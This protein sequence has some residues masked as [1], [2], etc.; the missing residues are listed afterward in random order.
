VEEGW[1]LFP[2]YKEVVNNF[3]KARPAWGNPLKRIMGKLKSC[4]W[5]IK[6][7][8]VKKTQATDEVIATKTRELEVLQKGDGLMDLKR[9]RE[10]KDEIHGLLEQQDLKWKQRAK[11]EWL[12]KGD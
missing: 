8:V 1:K 11:E 12:L 9:E 5:P 4:Q 3:W 2:Y 7:W 10:L 6:Q